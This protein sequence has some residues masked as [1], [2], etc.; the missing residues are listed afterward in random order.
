M[1]ADVS[2]AVFCRL[3]DTSLANVC[4]II[5]FLHLAQSTCCCASGSACDQLQ[6]S[7]P[8]TISTYYPSVLPVAVTFLLPAVKMI[9][10]SQPVSPVVLILAPVRELCMQIEDVA[11]A[12]MRGMYV[13]PSTALLT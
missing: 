2:V 5:L 11:K 3:H 12:L 4:V 13:V 1:Y 7:L 6:V 8:T 9:H 10:T